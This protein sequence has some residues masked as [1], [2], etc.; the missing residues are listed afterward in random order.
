MPSFML[1][2]LKLW[3]LEGYTKTNRQ[4]NK[5]SYFNNIDTTASMFDEV[6]GEDVP[7]NQ[8]RAHIMSL[9]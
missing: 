5:S 9:Q 7:S 4:T 1:I 2:G 3:S 6:E 8:S